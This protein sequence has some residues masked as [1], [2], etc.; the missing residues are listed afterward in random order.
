MYLK[1]V[2]NWVFR[3]MRKLAF[4]MEWIEYLVERWV[5]RMGK[6][7]GSKMARQMA[8]LKEIIMVH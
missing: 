5:M 1:S 2:C 8:E 7:K 4:Q 6:A 3:I